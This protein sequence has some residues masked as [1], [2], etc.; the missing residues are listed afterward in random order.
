MGALEERRCESLLFYFILF[1]VFSGPHPLHMEVSR[2]G[3][4][5]EL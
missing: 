5:L 2:L 1:F 3:V 4:E